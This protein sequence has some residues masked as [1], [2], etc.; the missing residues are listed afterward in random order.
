M[1]LAITQ[2]AA[3]SIGLLQ[4]WVLVWALPD[5]SVVDVYIASFR[6]SNFILQMFIISAFSVSLVPLLSKYYAEKNAKEMS[7]L[8]SS[9]TL[10]AGIVF[11]VLAL[12][13]AL[14]FE[15]IAPFLTQF[16]GESFTL[17][18]QFGRL[19]LISDFLILFGNAFGQY[20]ITVRRYWIYGITPVLYTAGTIFGA[21]FFTEH[22]GAFGPIVGTVCGAAVYAFLRLLAVMQADFR[23]YF[24]LWHPDLSEVGWMMLP[25]IAALGAVQLELLLFD[26]IASGLD[27]GS[28][29][30]NAYSR[31]FQ[32]VLVGVAGIALAQSAFSLLSE[33]ASQKDYDR[34]WIY[35]RRG[36]FLLLAL[37]IPASIILV[38]AA[39]IAAWLVN[40]SSVLGVF[41]ISLALYALS[42]PF[43]SMNHLLLR[44]FYALK[45]TLYPACFTVVNAVC[46]LTISWWLV[47]HFGVFSLALGFAVGHIVQVIGL[48]LTLKKVSGRLINAR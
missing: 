20:L 15:R 14:L 9:V 30:I 33:S 17:Y 29:T 34:F 40:L 43:E 5:I 21:V 18:V 7:K 42:A 16:E 1:V 36:T 10:V 38:F 13:L 27:A 32:S 12:L 6:P 48:S 11:G 24:T 19:A 45:N 2:L 35:V 8:L 23:P 31:D 41:T 39:P 46:A 37:T 22:I 28:I 25:R 26:R 44:S 47:P 4:R 3:S